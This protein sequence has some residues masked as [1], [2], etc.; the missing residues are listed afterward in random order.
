MGRGA[1]SIEEMLIRSDGLQGE[2][3]K[4]RIVCGSSWLPVALSCMLLAPICLVTGGVSER[5]DRRLAVTGARFFLCTHLKSVCV[6][7][8][9][10]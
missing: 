3:N 5:R 1:R 6:F 10:A 8:V 9:C 2:G 4:E 7:L